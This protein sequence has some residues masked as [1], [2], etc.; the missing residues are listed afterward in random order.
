MMDRRRFL[1]TALAGALVAPISGEAQQAQG[2]RRVGL[3][4]H[5][6]SIR[7]D[8]VRD[9]PQFLGLEERLRALGYMEGRNLS[10][11]VRAG[12]REQLP[13]LAAALVD[14]NVDVIVAWGT[15]QVYA[16]K[17]RTTSIPI[18]IG[19]AGDV[20]LTGLVASLRRPGANITGI[21]VQTS[22]LMT[23]QVQLIRELMP[24][25]SRVGILWD[26][27]T[28]AGA[29][30]R[31]SLEAMKR[32]TL[33]H[34][35][36]VEAL[37]TTELDTAFSTLRRAGVGGVAIFGGPR[38]FNHPQEVARAALAHG[39]ATAFNNP[40][41]VRAGGLMSYSPDW[42]QTGRQTADY[43]D[44]ILR[45]AKPADLP[46]EQPMRFAFTINLQTA[47][48]LGLAIPPSL[49]ARADQVIE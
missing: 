27:T 42:T 44:R 9:H 36:L 41:S 2:V 28:E 26:S 7:N 40:Q 4:F 37:T 47:K 23:K 45:G 19:S 10:F 31:E 35:E 34:F 14:L 46:I 5:W 39:L 16:A 3:L 18:V 48:A 33:L 49:L 24:K 30:V 32:T 20:L 13:E 29:V 12:P 11:V 6:N 1:L 21:S 17:R 15:A 8:P 38:Y 22:D 25:V 43:V